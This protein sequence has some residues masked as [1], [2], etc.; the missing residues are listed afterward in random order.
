MKS[1]IG[2]GFVTALALATAAMVMVEVWPT[3]PEQA[4]PLREVPWDSHSVNA[5]G[6]VEVSFVGAD[7]SFQSR[8][9]RSYVASA[10]VDDDTV[11]IVVTELGPKPDGDSACTLA[12]YTLTAIVDGLTAADLEGRTVRDGGYRGRWLY[13]PAGEP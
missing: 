9:A 5:A 8:C 13:E 3:L 1:F 11:E 2:I 7:P 12:G 6:E 4:V 10:S